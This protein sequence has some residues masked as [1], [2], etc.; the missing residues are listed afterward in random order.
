MKHRGEF[1]PE[2]SYDEIPDDGNGG[3]GRD[4]PT[5]T[6][7]PTALACC[8]GPAT[9]RIRPPGS[10]ETHRA[11]EERRALPSREFDYGGTPSSPHD[12]NAQRFIGVE[13]IGKS[14]WNPFLFAGGGSDS[15]QTSRGSSWQGEIRDIVVCC[16]G[17]KHCAESGHDARATGETDLKGGGPRASERVGKR[18]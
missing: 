15:Q 3:C 11:T 4:L 5:P 18:Q 16:V 12:N 2:L 10:S 1:L 8:I 6:R 17:H 9:S 7:N 13:H 14:R